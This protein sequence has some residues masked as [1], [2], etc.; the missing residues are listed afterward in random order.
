MRMRSGHSAT[1]QRCSQHRSAP[2]HSTHRG[3]RQPG[4][5][6][7][8][9]VS[10]RSSFPA[11]TRVGT[12][13]HRGSRDGPGRAR[14]GRRPRTEVSANAPR[15]PAKQPA[16]VGDGERRRQRANGQFT[17]WQSLKMNKKS[18]WRQGNRKRSPRCSGKARRAIR[19][20]R[21][22]T[23]SSRCHST[24]GSTACAEPKGKRRRG[25]T[26][27]LNRR[28]SMDKIFQWYLVRQFDHTVGDREIIQKRKFQQS[29]VMTY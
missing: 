29:R 14:S 28:E 18:D 13:H 11:A 20:C 9:C 2:R 6:G 5:F 10:D 8:G 23:E 12:T 1:R 4:S 26:R 22:P 19:R 25:A 16:R 7:Q 21:R 24:R 17:V 3:E 27:G 15:T